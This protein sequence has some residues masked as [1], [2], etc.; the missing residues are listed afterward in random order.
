MATPLDTYLLTPVSGGAAT[1]ALDLLTGLTPI[2][3]PDMGYVFA[4]L[5]DTYNLSL[6][7]NKYSPVLYPNSGVPMGFDTGDII[8]LYIQAFK[9]IH[10]HLPVLLSAAT[11][12][13]SVATVD[14]TPYGFTVA[15]HV[16]LTPVNAAAVS[17]SVT[18]VTPTSLS[19]ITSVAS[20][21]VQVLL[22]V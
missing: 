18:S 15:P 9:D 4:D 8:A 14:L 13:S 12:G 1:T 10:S 21:N 11:D 5:T 20:V 16:T 19:I 22:F 7:Q 2:R 3:D 17:A 6:A